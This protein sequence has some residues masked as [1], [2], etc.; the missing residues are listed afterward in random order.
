MH[1]LNES[2]ENSD[3]PPSLSFHCL[4]RYTHDGKVLPPAYAWTQPDATQVGI[5]LRY[6]QAG[7]SLDTTGHGRA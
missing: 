1:K 3:E 4:C 7:F 6:I 2:I 5:N